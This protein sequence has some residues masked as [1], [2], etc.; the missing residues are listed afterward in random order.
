MN[1]ALA[2]V[3]NAISTRTGDV[4][5]AILAG[6]AD[7]TYSVRVSFRDYL[8]LRDGVDGRIRGHDVTFE[9]INDEGV[10]TVG[11]EP[12]FQT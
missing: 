8:T 9:T 10:A 1:A 5:E 4:E 12:R 6:Q 2:H 7:D 3:E 11:V